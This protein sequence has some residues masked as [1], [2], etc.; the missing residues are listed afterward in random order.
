MYEVAK[1]NGDILG[2]FFA[3]AFFYIFTQIRSF[4]LN[5][6]LDILAFI[7]VLIDLAT[8]L[9]NW[10]IFSNLLVTLFSGL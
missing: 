6:A 10:A 8:F 2:Y 9:K 7:G 3:W 4:K 1:R 5:S